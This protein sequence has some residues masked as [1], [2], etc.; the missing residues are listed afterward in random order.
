[1]GLL[2]NPKQRKKIVD[3]ISRYNNILCVLFY[4]VGAIGF[5]ALAYEPL[6]AKTY[7]SEN[8]LLPGMLFYLAILRNIPYSIDT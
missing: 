2:S 4:V 7:F 6:N 3:A 1:M 5:F 8:A